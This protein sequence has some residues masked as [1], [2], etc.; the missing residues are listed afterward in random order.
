VAEAATTVEA[1]AT[2]DASAVRG[3]L[4][5]A[6][7]LGQRIGNKIGWF[8]CLLR[9]LVAAGSLGQRIG[10]KITDSAEDRAA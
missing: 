5:A 2:T 4:V 9:D 7:S 1:A 3:D 10:N 6:G 8:R